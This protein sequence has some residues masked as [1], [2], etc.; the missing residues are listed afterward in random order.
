MN[1][2]GFLQL[3]TIGSAKL[4]RRMVTTLQNKRLPSFDFGGPLLFASGVCTFRP[5]DY[6]NSETFS[7][8]SK[9]ILNPIKVAQGM[10]PRFQY[11]PGGWVRGG[12]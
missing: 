12:L 8:Q 11:D 5:Y 6:C 2:S 1:Q 9:L 7:Q 3:G 10:N 4:V